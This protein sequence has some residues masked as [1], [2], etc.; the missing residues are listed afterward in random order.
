MKILDELFKEGLIRCKSCKK[1]KSLDNFW[2]DKGRKRG[3][4]PQCKDCS[5]KRQRNEWE[6]FGSQPNRMFNRLIQLT[7]GTRA[8]KG[9]QRH[10]LK[11]SKKDFYTWYQN[12]EKKC[13]YCEYN[14]NEFN[15]IKKHFSKQI[16]KTQRFGI[17]RKN[18]SLP[19]KLDNIV[20]CCV[21]C[22]GLKGYFHDYPSFKKIANKYIKPK[23]NELT[24]IEENFKRLGLND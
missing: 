2:K 13:V 14:L 7:S 22:N 12:I 18:N 5:K 17:D 15:Q 23:L 11:I 10:K 4:D 21:I 1:T 20:L 8:T 3:Y 24:K 6:R 16:Q 9:H 19:Y